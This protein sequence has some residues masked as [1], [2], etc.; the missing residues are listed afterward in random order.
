MHRLAR[1]RRAAACVLAALPL[2]FLAAPAARATQGFERAGTLPVAPGSALLPDAHTHRLLEIGGGARTRPADP[3]APDDDGALTLTAYDTRT[4][5]RVR[6]A[7]FAPYWPQNGSGG[8]PRVHAFD[9]G[10][11]RLTVLAYGGEHEMNNFVNPVLVTLDV[12]A[13]RVVSTTPLTGIVPHGARVLGMRS[14]PGD[15]VMLV[16][17]ALPS[18]SVP[19]L[20]PVEAPRLAGVFLVEIG[21]AGGALTW[22]PALVRGCQSA[23]ANQTQ[24]LLG[25]ARDAVFLGCATSQVLGVPAPGLQAVAEVSVGDTTKQ[26]VYYLPGSY[27]S[28]DVYVDDDAERMLLVGSTVGS[29]AQA[30]WVFDL[31]HRVFV[32]QVASGDVNVLGAGLDERTGRMYVGVDGAVLVTTGRGLQIPQAVRFDVPANIG[33]ITPLPF[34]RSIVVPTRGPGSSWVFAVYRDRL[35]ADTFVPG[36]PRDYRA[37]DDLTADAPQYAT[38][39]QAF[40]MRVHTI[41]AVNAALQNVFPLQ[42]NYWR[43]PGNATGL[44]DGDRDVLFAR[45]V[46]AH[47]SADEASAEAI[48]ADRDANTHADYDTLDKSIDLPA[49]P[50]ESA[51]CRDFGNGAGAEPEPVEGATT[52]CALG[53]GSVTASASYGGVGLP[54]TIT[55]GESSSGVTLTR[56]AALGNVTFAEAR[57][58]VIAGSVRIALVRSE[59][60][61]RA[62]G[63]KGQALGDYTTIFKGVVAGDFSCDD[64]CD[65]A[66]VLAALTEEL[67]AAVRV[68]LPAAHLVATPGG[69]HGHAMRDPWEHQ[70]DV[71][72]NNQDETQ[73]QVP[74]LRL[75]FV[76]DK[77]LAS[78]VIVELAATSADATSLRVVPAK[79]VFVDPPLVPPALPS[80]APSLAPESPRAPAPATQPLDKVVRTLGHG[81]KVLLTGRPGMVVRSIA[82]WTLF[83]SPFFF[84]LRR[85]VLRQIDGMT[86]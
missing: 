26:R 37:L 10:A 54:G 42:G 25:F 34:A 84:A 71:V 64:D 55:V 12:D 79:R 49:W 13:L 8:R 18:A 82:L 80:L 20:F 53:K 35:P 83:V 36:T 39:S 75:T 3:V 17:Q 62:A 57:N 61:A 45:I 51:G 9:A 27:A 58:V 5:K 43:D 30:V 31:A 81:W 11:R 1:G 22:G 63:R 2:A 70:Q 56:D 23:I 44:K 73:Q 85:R 7:V 24:S 48:A 60:R 46:R 86:P 38:E 52:A 72:I 47:L 4:L 68:E 65:A 50:Y 21:R 59:A 32:G 29:P 76:N 40:G 33:P 66:R 6:H 77:S 41:G 67:G 19:L 14:R 15:K 69:A 74:A 16:A 78:R 28:G